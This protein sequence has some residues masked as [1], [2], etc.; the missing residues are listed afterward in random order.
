[1]IVMDIEASGISPQSYPIEFAWQH[2]ANPTLF[3]GFLIQP[4]VDWVYWSDYAE[5]QIH[6]ITRT[7]LETSGI[8]VEIAAHWLNEE[9]AGQIVYSDAVDYDRPWIK[10]LFAATLRHYTCRAP[11][12][13]GCT[14]TRK[15]SEL[16]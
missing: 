10:K 4:T 13:G 14:T 12:F 2:R 5:Q 15:V 16:H 3:D 7:E 9:L 6:R 11:R 8:S 1:M